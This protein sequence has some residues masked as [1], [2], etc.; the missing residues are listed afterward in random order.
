MVEAGANEV[1]EAEILDALDIAHGEIKKLCEAQ[2]ELQRRPASRRSRSRCRRST[3]RSLA[4]HPRALRRRAR[5]GHPGGGQARAPGRHE[6]RRGGAARGARRRRRG[7][8]TTRSAVRPSSSRSTSSRRTWS[9]GGSRSTRSGPT[10]ARPTR[11]G[12][13]RS[14]SRVAPRTHG[15]ALFTRGQTQAL[16]VA[17]LG[18]T[19]EEMR[20][21][22]LGLETLQAL[23]PPL[24]LPAVLGRGGGLHARAEAARHRPRRARGARA[25][26]GHALAGGVPLH[27]PGGLRHPRV[28][29]VVVDG[30]RVRV[31]P[32]ADGRPACRS[33]ARSPAS[34]W[35]L[36]RRATTTS[37]SPTSPAWRTTSATWTSRSPARSA[38][39][40]ALQM[41]IKIAGVTFD[42]LRDALEQAKEGRDIHPRQDGRGDRRAAA[43]SSRR[44]APRITS[45]QI[46][47]DKI[48]M[49][50]GKGGETIRA[51]SEEFEAQ[52]DVYDD[53]RSSSTPR[54]ASRA[55]RLIDRIRQMTKE[56]EVG[57][58]YKGKV[59][60]TT[61]FGA[62]VELA[63]GTDGLLHI[64]NIA[65]GQRPDTRR[66][67]AQ[68]RRRDRRARGRGRQGARPDRPAARRRSG[69]RRQVAPRSSPRW[70]PATPVAR[71]RRGGA[72]AAHAAAA[73]GMAAAAAAA[74][75]TG[76]TS[77]SGRAHERP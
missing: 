67:R 2:R 40:T 34:R 32:V 23:L 6:A 5:R 1:S 36:S 71:E 7:R 62:F 46:D 60:K 51:L 45:I 21:D 55:T 14:R 41:D 47:P 19:R 68:P 54:P 57:D 10:A 12:R 61:T 76:A 37:C 33:R 56:V 39:I 58:E 53:G 8:R 70:A 69:D 65:P 18:T 72:A 24:Q 20:L 13:S 75:T 44:Y 38:G 9:G 48:G 25:R 4:E 50:I 22:T 63:K 64:S 77:G 35:A 11:S 29:R 66:G 17:A 73:T 49:V 74:A 16:S 27:D 28:E 15:S 31:E 59:V 42:I 26:A 3:S 52:I 30:V 43:P